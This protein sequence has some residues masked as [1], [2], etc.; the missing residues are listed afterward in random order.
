MDFDHNPPPDPPID[1]SIDHALDP[2]IDPHSGGQKLRLGFS[3]GTAATAAALAAAIGLT[4]GQI[5]TEVLVKLPKNRQLTVSVLEGQIK[6]T[7]PRVCVQTEIIKDAGDDPDVTNQAHIGVILEQIPQG[8]IVQGGPGVGRV[9]KPGLVIPPGQWAINPVPLAMLAEN[10]EPFLRETGLKVTVFIRDGE[11]LALKT[12]NPKLGILGGL[13]VLG[14]TGLV[15]PFSH[16]A[17]TDTIDSALS[18]ARAMGLTEIILTTGG[19]SEDMAQ[20][21]NPALP[22]ETFVQ[23]ADYFEAALVKAAQKGFK[24][25]GLTVFFGKA[26]KEAAGHSCTHAHKND[27]DLKT[28]AQ[29]LTNVP[30]DIRAQIAQAPTALAAMDILKIHNQTE[31]FYIVAQKMIQSA[32][33]F[34]GPKPKIWARILDFDGQILA[35][36]I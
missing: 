31:A 4:H 17:Y 21:L 19:R 30:S 8:L 2:N 15:K 13:S 18:V 22:P 24:R 33:I 11:N 36:I 7:V 34:A 9:T 6:K 26:V 5:P 23:I 16:R 28:L 29:W 25:I 27:M 1:P 14:T 12:L 20:K 32:R 10:L 35:E 3:T